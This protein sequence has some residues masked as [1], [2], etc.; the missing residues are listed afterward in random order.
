MTHKKHPLEIALERDILPVNVSEEPT[1]PL[2]PEIEMAIDGVKEFLATGIKS[3][4]PENS[5][6]NTEN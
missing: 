1:E 2:P 6:N 4:M 5:E 3:E